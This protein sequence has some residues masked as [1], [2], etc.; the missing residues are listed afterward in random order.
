MKTSPQGVIAIAVHEGLVPAP[1][2]DSVGV[3][4][5]GVGHTKGAGDPDPAAMDKAMPNGQ[6]MTDAIAH[7]IKLFAEDLGKYEARV[8]RAVNVPLSQHQFDA[9][10][11]FDFN[12]G[13]IFKAKLTES[14]N[15]GDYQKAGERF[16]GWLKPP[17]IRG[18]RTQ[19]MNLFLKGTYPTSDVPIWGTDGNGRLRGIVS[20]M[21]PSELMAYLSET[22]PENMFAEDSFAF[23]MPPLPH[24]PIHTAPRNPAPDWPK[25]PVV[26]DEPPTQPK[27]PAQST[28]IRAAGMAAMAQA[29][30]LFAA[31]P[32]LDQT[33]KYVIAG[34][35]GLVLLCLAWIFSE[36]IKKMFEHGI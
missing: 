1:Y 31:W 29:G 9:L 13:G 14:L 6:A 26:H 5:Y 4:T 27:T 2:R 8:N 34:L 19:E 12:T 7:A 28:T 32:N 10:V 36:R 24:D 25:A 3:W 20:Q 18:R 22:R 21:K 11:S 23:A 35:A 30:S 15:A 17:E 16:M 33:D